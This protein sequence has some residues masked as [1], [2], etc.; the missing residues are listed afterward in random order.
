MSTTKLNDKGSARLYTSNGRVISKR[1]TPYLLIASHL[2]DKTPMYSPTNENIFLP[3]NT[4]SYA[5]IEMNKLQF[6]QAKS[7]PKAQAF[8]AGMAFRRATLSIQ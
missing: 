4:T 5:F 6:D 1:I 7:R 2:L 3:C 8:A